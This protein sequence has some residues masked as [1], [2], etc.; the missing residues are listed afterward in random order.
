MDFSKY[1]LRR[2]ALKVAY[3]GV[4]YCG[5]ARQPGQVRTIEGC[6]LDTMVKVRL[7]PDHDSARLIKCGRTDKGVSAACQVIAVSVRSSVTEGKGIER[8][9]VKSGPDEPYC[10]MLNRSLPEDIR[11]LAWS[12]VR[13]D[14][15]ARR[16]TVRRTYRYRLI[17]SEAYNVGAMQEAAAHLEGEHDFRSFC[18]VALDNTETHVRTIERFVVTPVNSEGTE[19]E[20]RVTGTAF[21]WHQVRAMAAILHLVGTGKE[22]PAIVAS[23]LEVSDDV[24]G[25]SYSVADPDPLCLWECEYDEAEFDWRVDHGSAKQARDLYAAQARQ[26]Q[27]RASVLQWLAEASEAALA[28]APTPPPSKR[29]PPQ[30]QRLADRPR[31]KSVNEHYATLSKRAR[32][33]VEG[34]RA[35]AK[36]YDEER[37]RKRS[38]SGEEEE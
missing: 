26:L 21:L 24:G 33:I 11:V 23:M 18:K 35:L 14:F 7:I 17:H 19:V 8:V 29:R 25:P 34:K 16:D 28:L 9:G 32:E 20:L 3:Y 5:L 6:L 1:S 30:Y 31:N 22:E 2:I 15:D 38:L 4:S 10:T 27:Q 36:Q 13:T 12:P 37:K